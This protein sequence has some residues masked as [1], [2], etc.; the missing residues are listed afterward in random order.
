MYENTEGKM[1]CYNKEIAKNLHVTIKTGYK[2]ACTKIRVG[3]YYID[4]PPT[5][6]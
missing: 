5:F 2:Q 1:L 3:I 4:M 6:L